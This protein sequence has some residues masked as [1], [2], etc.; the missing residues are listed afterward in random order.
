MYIK[1]IHHECN[2]MFMIAKEAVSRL[3]FGVLPFIDEDNIQSDWC[4]IVES[5]GGGSNLYMTH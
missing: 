3:F 5:L 1:H 4:K 2:G